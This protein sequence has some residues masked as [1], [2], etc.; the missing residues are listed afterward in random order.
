MHF[1]QSANYMYVVET[2]TNEVTAASVTVAISLKT[3]TENSQHSV[4]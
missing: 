3:A 4:Y 2:L 1:L